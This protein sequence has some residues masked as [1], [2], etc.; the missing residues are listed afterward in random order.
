M[1][2]ENKFRKHPYREL[3]RLNPDAY[4]VCGFEDAYVG[5]SVSTAGSIVA[6]YDYEACLEILASDY[7]YEPDEAE[8]HMLTGIVPWGSYDNGPIF[9]KWSSDLR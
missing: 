7:D 6:V 5:H 2:M 4:V 3:R 1:I 9:V 8:E